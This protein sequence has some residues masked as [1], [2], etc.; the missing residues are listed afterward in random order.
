MQLKEAENAI[1]VAQKNEI[2]EHFVYEKLSQSIK[3][4]DNREVLKRISNDELRHYGFWKK[5]TRR[6]IK[7]NKLKIWKY[8]FIISKLFGITFGIKLMERNE[9]KA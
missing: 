7:P 6:D 5:H 1:L 4:P 8:F 9:E 3:D 2:T